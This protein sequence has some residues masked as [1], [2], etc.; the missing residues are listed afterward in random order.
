M[1]RETE[2]GNAVYDKAAVSIERI[3]AMA[4]V[5]ERVY[6]GYTV[7]VS[8]GKDSTVIT[9]LAVR[10][11][12][13]ITFR[14]SWT[15]I[16]YPETARFLRSEKARAEAMGYSFEFAVPRG[17]DG[18]RVT[19]WTLIEK[20]GFPTRLRRFCCARLKERSGENSYSILGI[21][22]AESAKRKGRF[23]HETRGR[24][25]MSNS[26]NGMSRRMTET[27]AKKN[28][29]I[30]NPIIDWTEDEV[31]EYIRGRDLPYNP[32]Y[33]RGAQARR[34]YRVPDEKE[35]AGA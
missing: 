30:L 14:T 8:G 24:A 25:V 6:G 1:L 13:K 4:P 12:V 16:E 19:M 21:R 2:L 9:D 23:I 27:C 11:G 15:G 22:W 33:D 18:K 5:A 26:D 3:R 17:K 10:S 28:G 29:I 20:Q 32:L 34:V 35:P 7:M 31:W